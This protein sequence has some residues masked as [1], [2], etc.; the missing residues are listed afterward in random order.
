MVVIFVD[1]RTFP[2]LARP[3]TVATK[4]IPPST[5]AFSATNATAATLATPWLKIPARLAAATAA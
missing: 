5:A 4:I 2:R 1:D 3:T